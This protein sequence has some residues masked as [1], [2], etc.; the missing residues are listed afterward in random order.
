M[1]A[2]ENSKQ[3]NRQVKMIWPINKAHIQKIGLGTEVRNPKFD[4]RNS[5]RTSGPQ[6]PGSLTPYQIIIPLISV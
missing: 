2:K 1:K 4:K 3:H 6:Q 5:C